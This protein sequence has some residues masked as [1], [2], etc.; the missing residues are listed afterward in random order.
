MV[1]ILTVGQHPPITNVVQG[2]LGN[3]SYHRLKCAGSAANDLN[4]QDANNDSRNLVGKLRCCSPPL[5]LWRIA[6]TRRSV[7]LSAPKTFLPFS[8]FPFL[9]QLFL[10][11]CRNVSPLGK[12]SLWSL[13]PGKETCTSLPIP[14]L[15]NDEG[16]F[17]FVLDSSNPH[18]W[19]HSGTTG[20][21]L[22]RQF[23]SPD[24]SGNFVS[25]GI[26]FWTICVT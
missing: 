21:S 22:P 16:P 9:N 25:A 4:R 13:P 24:L 15:K 8:W 3:L 11:A 5:T 1:C 7:P 26:F 12:P 17:G 20:S 6:G 18:F 14:P 19:A 10:G 23:V 2:R